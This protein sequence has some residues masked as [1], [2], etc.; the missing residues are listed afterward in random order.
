MYA[1]NGIFVVRLRG[2]SCQP[3]NAWRS[4]GCLPSAQGRCLEFDR[5]FIPKACLTFNTVYADQ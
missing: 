5:A 4:G 2:G 3:D 1:T